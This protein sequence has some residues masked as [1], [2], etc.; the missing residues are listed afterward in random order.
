MLSSAAEQ[1]VF[2]FLWLDPGDLGF[3]DSSCKSYPILCILFHK[4]LVGTESDM[5]HLSL[6]LT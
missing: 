3:F 5:P 4:V 1:A 6:K 2:L